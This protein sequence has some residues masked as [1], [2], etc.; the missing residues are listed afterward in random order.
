MHRAHGHPHRVQRTGTPGR[1]LPHPRGTHGLPRD[2]F[3]RRRRRLPPARG[4]H[5]AI[6]PLRDLRLHDGGTRAPA[7]RRR[8]CRRP[9]PGRRPRVRQDHRLPPGQH[10]RRR[11]VREGSAPDASPRPPGRPLRRV[12]QVADR[13]HLQ[14][15]RQRARDPHQ[16]RAAARSHGRD[17]PA[18]ERPGPRPQ[19]RSHELDSPRRGRWRACSA[20][21]TPM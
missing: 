20:N 15:R 1:S 18:S 3:L 6:R 5:R 4:G 12:A 11:G 2:Q 8:R 14:R 21:T 7:G 9:E 19:P 13:A 10:P 17:G 16:P